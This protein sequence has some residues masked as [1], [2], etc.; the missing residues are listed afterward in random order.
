MKTVYIVGGVVVVLAWL[1]VGLVIARGPQPEIVVPAEKLWSIGPLNITNTL[2]TS[3]VVMIVMIIMSVLATR[4]M[5]LLPS[6]FQNFMEAS[7]S[8]LVDQIVEIA[9]DKNGRRFF[10]VV[11]TLFLYILMCNWFG[12]LPFFNAIGK[13]DDVGHEVFEQIASPNP[14]KLKLSNGVYTDDEKFAGWKSTESGSVVFVKSQAKAD[15]LHSAEGR[16]ARRGDGPLH[17]VP[18]AQLTPASRR[19]KRSKTHRRPTW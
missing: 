15:R 16:D 18:R 13:T 1:A 7:L 4:G 19:R 2:L 17:R 11:A 10:A 12:L 3:W 9:G 6:G 5:K 8:Y 14:D